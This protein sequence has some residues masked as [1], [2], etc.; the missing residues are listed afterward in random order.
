M[1]KSMVAKAA[2]IHTLCLA[3]ST[4]AQMRRNTGVPSISGRSAL[5]AR[6]G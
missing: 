6:T 3:D 2:Q 5:P 4:A 1:R